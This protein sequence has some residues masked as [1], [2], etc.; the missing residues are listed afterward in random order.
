MNKLQRGTPARQE[1]QLTIM[2]SDAAIDLAP[3]Q[4]CTNV[5]VNVNVITGGIANSEPDVKY[6]THDS[7]KTHQ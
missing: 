2:P 3:N 6:D 4:H 1:A 5:N 7:R